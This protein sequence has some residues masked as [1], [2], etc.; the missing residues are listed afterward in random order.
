MLAG[1]AAGWLWLRG[2]PG[3]GHPCCRKCGFDLVGSREAQRCP[4]CGAA[5]SARRAM[6]DRRRVRS[7][8]VLYV[9]IGLLVAG[10]VAGGY[11]AK[12]AAAAVDWI[13]HKPTWWLVRD[14]RGRDPARVGMVLRELLARLEA[15]ALSDETLLRVALQGLDYRDNGAPCGR[16]HFGY[17][18]LLDAAWKR[19]LLNREDARNYA[20]NAVGLWWHG[21]GMRTYAGAPPNPYF[22]VNFVA[23]VGDSSRSSI[24]TAAV[25]FEVREFSATL[26]GEPAPTELLV[27]RYDIAS[28]DVPEPS[29]DA[30]LATAKIEMPMDWKGKRLELAWEI[31]I[32]DM[33]TRE[34][35]GTPWRDHREILLNSAIKGGARRQ[36]GRVPPSIS[37]W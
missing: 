12:E 3:D 15:G 35:I 18:N 29:Y 10:G 24:T 13:A 6:V 7:R 27:R 5:L 19:G 2:R 11:A 37:R 30:T 16:W 4:E 21:P 26:D 28:E 31:Q 34:P 32:V 17:G 23:Y 20:V 8:S 9:S 1:L 36:D 14:T 33:R 25:D 22:G